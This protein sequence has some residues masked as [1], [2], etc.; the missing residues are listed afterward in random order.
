M[1]STYNFFSFSSVRSLVCASLPTHSI[2]FVQFPYLD[3]SKELQDT[4]GHFVLSKNSPRLHETGPPGI[5]TPTSGNVQSVCNQETGEI[6]H[7]LFLAD[8]TERGQ[9]IRLHLSVSRAPGV[10]P[11]DEVALRLGIVHTIKSMSLDEIG[12][13]LSHLENMAKRFSSQASSFVAEAESGGD[14]GDSEAT[15]ETIA[16]TTSWESTVKGVA[17]VTVLHRMHF[18]AATMKDHIAMLLIEDTDNSLSHKLSNRADKLLWQNVNVA[19]IDFCRRWNGGLLFNKLVKES[20][21]EIM[22]LLVRKWGLNS[23]CPLSKKLLANVVSIVACHILTTSTKRDS[24][25]LQ[26][27]LVENIIELAKDSEKAIKTHCDSK[28]DLEAIILQPNTTECF[29]SGPDLSMYPRHHVSSAL[30][31]NAFIC[32]GLTENYGID[33]ISANGGFIVVKLTPPDSAPSSAILSFPSDWKND[34]SGEIL[35]QALSQN[36]STTATKIT[37]DKDWYTI[38]QL[39]ETVDRVASVGLIKWTKSIVGGVELPLYSYAML[40]RSVFGNND[41][42]PTP[43]NDGASGTGRMLHF[44]ANCDGSMVSANRDDYHPK[45]LPFFLGALWPILE[46]QFRWRIH[47]GRTL[48]CVS[49]IL[50]EA[51]ERKRRNVALGNILASKKRGL[52]S[53]RIKKARIPKLS[54]TLKHILTAFTEKVASETEAPLAS[55]IVKDA[56][57]NFTETVE[58]N[59]EKTTEVLHALGEITL[60]LFDEIIPLTALN[61][62]SAFSSKATPGASRPCEKYG[63]EHL[64][65]FVVMLPDMLD[66]CKLGYREQGQICL[67]LGGLVSFLSEN[68]ANLFDQTSNPPPEDS[69]GKD[70]TFPERM[71]HIVRQEQESSKDSHES[72][73]DQSD[74]HALDLVAVMAEDASLL[75]EYNFATLEQTQICFARQADLDKGKKRA[76]KVGH[77]GLVCIHCLNAGEQSSR[78]FLGNKESLA[79]VPASIYMHITVSCKHCP[80][81]IKDDMIRKKSKHSAQMKLLKFGSQSKFFNA[82]WARMMR[83]RRS[84]IDGYVSDG[85]DDFDDN[86]QGKNSAS[87][88]AV[89]DAVSPEDNADDSEPVFYNHMEALAFLESKDSYQKP[90]VLAGIDLYYH[91]LKVGGEMWSTR[92]MPAKASSEWIFK[93]VLKEKKSHNDQNAEQSDKARGKRKM[94]PA[95]TALEAS[96]DWACD[97]CGKI[98][99]GKISRC[100]NPCWRWRGGIHP[101]SRMSGNKNEEKKIEDNKRQKEKKENS[102]KANEMREGSARKK[103]GRHKKKKAVDLEDEIRQEAYFR[104]TDDW[105][106]DVC[107]KINPGKIT[108]CGTPCFRWKGGRHPSSFKYRSLPDKFASPAGPSSP[109]SPKIPKHRLMIDPSSQS[110]AKKRAKTDASPQQFY[111]ASPEVK[112]QAENG[113]TANGI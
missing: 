80:Q 43:R 84:R 96:Q 21:D 37:I 101:M 48:S 56:V 87:S 20:K 74:L 47:A 59:D 97:R 94:K 13:V 61:K 44:I 89:E 99:S 5:S 76:F 40:K 93:K 58:C 112:P 53:R 110:N 63:C 79:T 98:N 111:H 9:T 90:D 19:G 70:Q 42:I 54:R 81:E 15:H 91:C 92:T 7:L 85:I 75:S 109:A 31:L 50:P 16:S 49:F 72:A 55:V 18:I 105:E 34:G 103:K 8:P 25:Y 66:K 4:F 46:K 52:T 38:H 100:G 82:L 83:L 12:V 10:P 2:F 106:C 68:H 30:D 88:D 45:S 22:C 27:A 69:L 64:L 23:I 62:T 57:R 77:P 39:V 32:S 33:R 3:R 14:R 6:R 36:S 102:P 17:I 104:Q 73:G 41:T 35:V 11:E 95:L 78:Y 67:Y 65:C 1:V 26:E 86:L 24:V 107:H 29:S 113:A 28:N 51:L 71:C 60:S 108:R